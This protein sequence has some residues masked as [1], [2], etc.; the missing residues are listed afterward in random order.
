MIPP[1][2]N[3][4]IRR[5][6]TFTSGGASTSPLSD[7]DHSIFELLQQDGRLPF[8]T[9]AD[10]LGVDET[11]VR[12]RVE[13][14]I[15]HDVFSITVVA[16]PRVLGYDHMAWVGISTVAGEL[17]AVA[18]RLL[19]VPEVR[20]LVQCSGRL[21]LMAEVTCTSAPELQ[22]VLDRIR[23]VQGVASL[24]SA[25]YLNLFHQGFQWLVSDDEGNVSGALGDEAPTP[26]AE[27]L[28]LIRELS[29]DGR[30]S[31]REIGERLG[32]SGRAVSRRFHGLVN[33]RIVQVI[34][35]AN[36][37]DVGLGGMA[38][39]GITL[40]PGATSRSVAA[41]LASVGGLD[42]IVI[43]TGSW[44]LMAEIVGRDRAEVLDALE[45]DIARIQG[46]Q[47]VETLL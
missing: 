40:A 15:R 23:E 25:L 42:Y 33:R 12:R 38:W 19:E 5:Q 43:P 41:Q 46:I 44:D 10:R 18:E 1:D 8:V 32:V 37:M 45:T 35:V 16:N 36:P 3:N 24:E 30:A 47:K 34:A 9:I 20:Y 21:S 29:Q 31:F 13:H 2:T 28:A 39:L 14:L 7:F 26:D 22:R 17:A 4:P 6:Q 11:R 27:D